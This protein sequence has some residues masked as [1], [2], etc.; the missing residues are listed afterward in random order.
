[1][2]SPFTALPTLREFI[3]RAVAQGCREGAVTGVVGPRGEMTGRY[4]AAPGAK[5]AI[6]ILPNI[7]DDEHLTPSMVASL[8]RVLK[9]TGFEHCYIDDQSLSDDDYRPEKP[10]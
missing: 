10:S 7:R 6:K 1:M 3:E 4:L 5:G 2:A 8:V 9:V